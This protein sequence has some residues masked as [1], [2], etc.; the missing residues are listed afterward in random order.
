MGETNQ[1]IELLH[2]LE[3]TLESATADPAE[4]YIHSVV[5]RKG[6]VDVQIIEIDEELRNELG[7]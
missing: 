1:I 3:F 5:Y 4:P 2:K 7:M 6:S